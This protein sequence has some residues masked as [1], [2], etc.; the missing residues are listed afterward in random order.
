MEIARPRAED[1]RRKG[2]A[3]AR[4]RILVADLPRLVGDLVERTIERQDDMVVVAHCASLADLSAVAARSSPDIVIAG[5]A[6]CTLPE[7]CVEL[8]W[9]RRGLSVLGIEATTGRTWLYGLRLASPASGWVTGRT[10]EV[11]G[12][13]PPE[14]IPRGLPDLMPD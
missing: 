8:M 1:R 4:I 7:P 5:V 11:D 2:V 6:G 13:A 14:L 12:L 10:L 9:E 3:I